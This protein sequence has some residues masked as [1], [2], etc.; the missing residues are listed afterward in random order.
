[1]SLFMEL[2]AE[3]RITPLQYSLLSTLSEHGAADQ[4]TLA[5]AVAL[6]RTT[7]TGALKRLES[8]GLIQR[9]PSEQ[10]RRA[11]DCRMT[12]EGTALLAAM[13]APA[14][15]AHE[16]TIA[17]LGVDDRKTLMKLLQRV[18]AAHDDRRATGMPQD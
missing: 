7:T 13:Q 5:R 18:V 11:Q 17:S 2:C 9:I 6:D 14:R 3:F 12:P 10:D 1:M 8:R 4:S 16:A 15:E